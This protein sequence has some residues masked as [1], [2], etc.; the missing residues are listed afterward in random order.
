[1]ASFDGAKTHEDNRL[2]WANSDGLSANA[3]NSPEVR[4]TL[5]NRSQ[6]EDDNNPNANGLTSDAAEETIGTGPRLQ[7]DIDGPDVDFETPLPDDLP[8][9]IEKK[10]KGWAKAVGLTDHLLTAVASEITR[11]EVFLFSFINPGLADPVQLALR[12]YETDQIHTP[13]FASNQLVDGIEF[14]RD[15]NPTWYH[16]LKQHPGDQGLTWSPTA[17]ADRVPAR[18][19]IHLFKGR[20]PSQARGLP[21]FTS[22]LSIYAVLR[23]YQM[24]CLQSAEAQARIAGVIEQEN[25]LPDDGGDDDDG[26]GEQIQYAGVHLLTLTA[27]QT[28]RA[29]PHTSPPPNYKEFKAEGLT[30]AGRPLCAPRNISIG[31][32]ADYNYAS[33]RLDSQRWQR[34]I[35]LRR[36]RIERLALNR[37]F[38]EW[39]AL[40]LLTPGYLPP[41]TPPIERWCWRWRWDGFVSIDPV[42]DAKAATERL[43]NG[44]SSLDRECGDM[45]E[46]WE[47]V[48]DQRLAEESRE[49]KRREALGLPPKTAPQPAMKQPAPDPEEAD[50]N[51]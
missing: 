51:D 41:G 30:D 43:T 27:G 18:Q 49:I 14:D 34:S 20:R 13:W 36:D 15:G 33:A 31:S 42:K 6:Y 12:L 7:L 29:L 35:R 22:S 23:R 2:H 17:E 28:A 25:A 24:A 5:R 3:A 47:D 9:E 21:T 38:R 39:A 19:M 37:I 32:S 4:R 11:G 16:V 44:T 1:M 26:A 46:D 45:G 40:A 8:R 50:A 48:Q 10:W